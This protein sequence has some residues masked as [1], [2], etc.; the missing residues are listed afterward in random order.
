MEVEGDEADLRVVLDLDG[1]LSL[2]GDARR[3]WRWGSELGKKRN[4]REGEGASE[5]G[6]Q[7]SG[8]GG[9]LLIHPA[10]DKGEGGPASSGAWSGEHAA[11]PRGHCSHREEGDF[12]K[13]PLDFVFHLHLGP[14]S[15]S[16]LKSA[17][18][19]IYLR[20]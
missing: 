11:V 18:L 14:F 4:E 8:G 6:E 19:G 2:D 3:Q 17:A 13:S 10:G 5:D 15:Y 1:E 9:A 20:H 16:S 7:R 12:A